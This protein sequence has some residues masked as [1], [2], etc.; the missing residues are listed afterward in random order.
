MHGQT[1]SAFRRVDGPGVFQFIKSVRRRRGRALN[2]DPRPF[3]CTGGR[4][5]RWRTAFASEPRTRGRVRV[6]YCARP[7][8]MAQRDLPIEGVPQ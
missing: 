3:H 8:C 1:S 5:H 2:R 4:R 7:S 6:E